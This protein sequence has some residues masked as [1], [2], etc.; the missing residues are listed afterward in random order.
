MVSK[1]GPRLSDPPKLHR[2]RLIEKH[3]LYGEIPEISPIAHQFMS[4]YYST[5]TSI[6]NIGMMLMMC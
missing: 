6:N 2:V 5:L 3:G 4:I 1:A